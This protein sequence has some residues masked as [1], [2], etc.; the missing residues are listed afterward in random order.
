MVGVV[1][2]IDDPDSPIQPGQEALVLVPGSTAM[3]EYYLA[4]T[5][6]VLPLP[7]NGKPLDHQ[8][9]AQQLGTVIYS[10]K[11]LPNIVNKRVAVIGQ[12]SAGLW[13]N[14]MVRRLGARQVIAVDLQAHRLAISE[15]YGA[16]H[17]VH[18]AEIDTVEAVAEL[19][20][21]EMPEVVIE[22]AGEID[23]INLAIDLVQ[24]HGFLFY[25][26]VP[27]SHAPIPFNIFGFF[28]KCINAQAMVGA[29]SDPGHACTWQALDLIN[30]GI[31]DVGPMLTHHF[32]FDQVLEA[33]EL[34]THP[35]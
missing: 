11:A 35:R 20:N 18:N 9:Q 32:A 3:A 25:F 30:R 4:S 24:S 5:Y 34:Q 10:T 1:E 22:A 31:A 6:H 19:T 21:G 14:F 12:G 33:Y 28:R 7:E 17:T 29:L 16:T 26:G 27:R 15:H 2:A 8:L 23:S 13:W